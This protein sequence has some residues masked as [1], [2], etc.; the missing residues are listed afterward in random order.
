MFFS[1]NFS[2]L[3]SVVWKLWR[4][5]SYVSSQKRVIGFIAMINIKF[6]VKLGK[7]ASDICAVLS[8]SYG[9]EAMKTSSFFF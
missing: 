9:A 5:C 4:M 3:T 6:C 1:Y 7:N 2:A 8:E